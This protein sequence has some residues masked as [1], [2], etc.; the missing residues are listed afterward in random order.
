MTSITPDSDLERLLTDG[1][2][3][4]EESLRAH[5]RGGERVLDQLTSH[6][7]A[8]GGKRMRP[9]LTM[10]VAQLGEPGVPPNQRVIEAAVA[11]ELTHLA[12]LYHDDVMDDATV[13]R[14]TS[15]AHQKWGNSL[16]I[17]AGD[18][19]F[20]RA[21]RIVA[22]LGERAVSQHADTFE[23][24]CMGQMN[25]TIGPEA[26]T[27]RIDF[28]LQVLADKTG[29]LV[30]CA[31]QYGAELSGCSDAVVEAVKAYGE[32]MGVA[33]QLADDILD[34]RSSKEVL[35]KTP[36]T[37]L[38]EDV[39]TM[40]VLLLRKRLGG[41][42]PPLP[43]G[44]EPDLETD[45]GILQ[46]IAGDLS[47]DAALGRVVAAL[48]VHPVAQETIDMAKEWVQ[49]AVDCLAPVPDCPA[50]QALIDFAASQVERVR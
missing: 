2:A 36:G 11:V 3:Q 19:I 27:N 31:A 39:D 42:I 26:G 24:L 7:A 29:S 43:V 5:L 45:A 21:S 25:E 48:A 44:W 13:R 16:A 9:A 23:R 41:E 30:A 10:L 38:R 15:A 47:D 32:A 33:F 34:L 37:D 4:V 12:T 8:A 6:L 46:A 14:G 28:Y 20:A 35:G 18:L 49:K 1:L 17:L 40:P 50:K 22:A